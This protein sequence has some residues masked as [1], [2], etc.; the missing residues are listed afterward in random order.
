MAKRQPRTNI[1]ISGKVPER[2][3]ARSEER[4]NARQS[5]QGWYQSSRPMENRAERGDYNYTRNYDRQHY[6][7][8]RRPPYW[9][10]NYGPRRSCELSWGNNASGFNRSSRFYDP[11]HI[12][13]NASCNN[14]YTSTRLPIMQAKINSIEGSCLR[15]TGSNVHAI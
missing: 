5:R 3:R 13:I 6:G 12:Y 15:D 1:K 9:S 8:N 7:H 14:P 10:S 2:E 11:S 4:F